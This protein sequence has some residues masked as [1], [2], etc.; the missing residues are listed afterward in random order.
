METKKIEKK[1]QLKLILTRF[2]PFFDRDFGLGDG[3]RG[4]ETVAGQMLMSMLRFKWN[5]AALRGTRSNLLFSGLFQELFARLTDQVKDV[6]PAVVCGVRTQVNLTPDDMIELVCT[7]KVVLERKLIASD[8]IDEDDGAVSDSTFLDELEIRRREDKELRELAEVVESGVSRLFRPKIESSRSTVIVDQLSEEMKRAH[9]GFDS[10]REL[11]DTSTTSMDSKSP[12]NYE[13]SPVGSW[14]KSPQLGDKLNM[15]SPCLTPLLPPP[16]LGCRSPKRSSLVDLLSPK[17]SF[18]SR[19]KTYTEGSKTSPTETPGTPTFSALS[20]LR[21]VPIGHLVPNLRQPATPISHSPNL[22]IRS[23]NSSIHHVI[24]VAEIPVELTPLHHVTGG[25]IVEYLGTVS[26][27][28]IRESSGLEAAE[29]HRFVT[30]C[31]AIARAHV[32]SLGGNA[33]LGK[34]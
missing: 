20:I 1:I 32:L 33:M 7:G 22:S 21:N 17:S 15:S 14:P 5:P 11:F 16:D 26:M 27:H 31:N 29:F 19:S 18:L 12:T 8:T 6:A 24:D 28:F 9:L 34:F 23:I 25:R 30:E 2:L 3:G 13:K 10:S 4:Q